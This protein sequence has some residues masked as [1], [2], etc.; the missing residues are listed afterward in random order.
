MLCTT[1]VLLV[2][3]PRDIYSVLHYVIFYLI[4]KSE[5]NSAY[6]VCDADSVDIVFQYLRQR[7]SPQNRWSI[8]FE[9]CTFRQEMTC[10]LDFLFW[11]GAVWRGRYVHPVQIGAEF[12]MICKE[13]C[14]NEVRPKR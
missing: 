13:L 10:C 5:V 11:A 9:E 14:E 8:T 7:K 4:L 6:E 3:I 12:S 1:R 2:G